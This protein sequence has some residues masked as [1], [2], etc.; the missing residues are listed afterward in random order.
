MFLNCVKTIELIGQFL[1]MLLLCLLEIKTLS[2]RN[3]NY[4]NKTYHK[5]IKM[6]FLNKSPA[7]SVH[8]SKKK[9]AN[10]VELT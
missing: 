5:R 9:H 4:N 6:F 8:I 10:T 3:K 2:V 1:L 7:A